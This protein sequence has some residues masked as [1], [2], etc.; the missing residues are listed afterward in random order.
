MVFVPRPLTPVLAVLLLAACGGGGGSDST[1]PGGP[2]GGDGNTGEPPPSDGGAPGAPPGSG[3]GGGSGSGSGGGSAGGGTGSG[4][5]SQQGAPPASSAPGT[6]LFARTL[7]GAGSESATGR[8]AFAVDGSFVALSFVGAPSRLGIARFDAGGATVWSKVFD[9]AQAAPLGVA[10]SPLGNV[11]L[12]FWAFDE[13]EDLGGGPIPARTAAVV[14]LAPDGRFVWQRIFAGVSGL[15]VDGS[16][17]ALVA[18]GERVVKLRWDGAEL[19]SWPVPPEDRTYGAAAVAFDPSGNAIVASGSRVHKLAPDGRQLWET[20][21]DA[22]RT[23]FSSLGTTAKG[24]VVAAG[25][26]SDHLR[27]AGSELPPTTDEGSGSFVLAVEADGRPRWARALEGEIG[28]VAVDPAGRLAVIEGQLALGCR[29]VLARWDLTGKELWRR[30]VAT[31]DGGNY[32]GAFARGVAV[33]PSG[34]IWVQGD[35]NVPFDVGTGTLVPR[36]SD[37]FLMRVA[38]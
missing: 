24:T 9:A 18:V 14:K 4:E 27:F 20:P 19:W 33:A 26:F 29:D 17:S 10:I 11:F 36:E 30:P 2:G 35:S 23:T 21:I 38:P 32:D 12:A 13:M 16:G 15:A 22:S 7:G 8:L 1:A 28:A 3:G 6:T 37:W 25:Y 5:G 34:E 31:C